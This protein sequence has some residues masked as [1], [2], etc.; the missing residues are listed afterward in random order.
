MTVGVVIVVILLSLCVGAM[1]QSFTKKG[2]AQAAKTAHICTK[3][4]VV[5]YVPGGPD[6][7]VWVYGPHRTPGN[8]CDGTEHQRAPAWW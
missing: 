8:A 3:H 7:L 5:K 1:V 4:R 2:K 6:H